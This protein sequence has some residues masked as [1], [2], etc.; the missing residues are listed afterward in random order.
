M[1]LTQASAQR[2]PGARHG[3]RAVSEVGDLEVVSG[4]RDQAMRGREAPA[5]LQELDHA[6]HPARGG[7]AG[8]VDPGLG[9]GW[10]QILN[11]GAEAPRSL[12]GC[13][14]DLVQGLMHAP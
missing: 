2:A 13:V 8:D 4:R 1:P 14:L 10:L 7:R 9:D 5:T 3:R 11:E 6:E 12:P